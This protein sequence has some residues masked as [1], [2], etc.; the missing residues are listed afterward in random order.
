MRLSDELT[1]A[2]IEIDSQDFMTGVCE[3]FRV[4]YPATTVDALL[5]EPRRLALPFIDAVRVRFNRQ[6]LPESLVCKTLLNARK[7][8]TLT[9]E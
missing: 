5:C 9:D 1:A 4:M 2:G 8:G 3:L 6:D 7:Q